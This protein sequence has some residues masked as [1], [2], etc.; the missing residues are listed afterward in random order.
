M[1][2]LTSWLLG[3]FLAVSTT[4]CRV[5]ADD[6]ARAA[7]RAATMQSLKKDTTYNQPS[8]EWS[9]GLVRPDDPSRGRDAVIKPKHSNAAAIM[10]QQQLNKLLADSVARKDSSASGSPSQGPGNEPE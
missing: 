6:I 7:A 9:E 5:A 4:G 3:S 2:K 8:H 1:N 10:K